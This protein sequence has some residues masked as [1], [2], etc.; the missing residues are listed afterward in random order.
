MLL[1][2]SNPTPIAHEAALINQLLDE[3]LEVLHLRKPDADEMEHL[4]RQINPEHYPRIAVHQHHAL[5]R[6]FG[7]SRFH[8][9]VANREKQGEAIRNWAGEERVL[10]TSIHQQEEYAELP[11]FFAYTF[12]GPVYAS[13]SK[14]GYGPADGVEIRLPQLA[15]RKTRLVALGGIDETNVEKTMAMGFDGVAVLGSIWQHPGQAVQRFKRLQLQC[16]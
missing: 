11:P 16:K 15:R 12:F 7:L 5:G 9:P 3:G 1:V 13:L 10:S 2:I 4:L 14:P 8:F 6:E